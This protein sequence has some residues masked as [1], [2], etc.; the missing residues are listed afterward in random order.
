[1]KIPLK[2]RKGEIV[3]YALVDEEDFEKVSAK[4]WYK[5]PHGYLRGTFNNTTIAM[6]QYIIGKAPNKQVINYINQN[7]LDNRKENLRYATYSQIF[8]NQLKKEGCSSKYKGAFWISSLQKWRSESSLNGH[9]ITLGTFINELDAAK[10]YDTFVYIHYGPDAQTNGTVA[11]ED[12]KDIDINTL[13]VGKSNKYNLPKNISK[14]GTSYLVRIRYNKVNYIK[15]VSKLDLA[16]ET[17]AAFQ[18]EI[19]VTLRQVNFVTLKIHIKT[20]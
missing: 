1:M 19:D 20:I 8:Q 11:Y 13:I 7:K 9:K 6:H 5:D 15:C 4:K 2:N 14:I 10:T 3:D 16:K 17:L 18:K 12:V